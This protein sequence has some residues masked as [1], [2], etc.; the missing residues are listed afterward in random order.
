MDKA[1]LKPRCPDT[2]P[3][4]VLGTTSDRRLLCD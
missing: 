3:R 1:V 4:C 2:L